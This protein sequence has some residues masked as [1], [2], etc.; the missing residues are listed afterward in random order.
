MVAAVTTSYFLL[1]AD[2]GTEPNAFD[3]I[4]KGYVSPHF[5]M[6]KNKSLVEFENARVLVTAQKISTV[7]DIV[8]LLEKTA[9]LSV[10]L[11]II[12]EKI[13]SRVLETLVVNKMRGFKSSKIGMV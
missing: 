3:Q 9:Q 4:D 10:P 12:A 6:N 11:F 5:I 8:P 2:Y 7:K 13:S 1:T